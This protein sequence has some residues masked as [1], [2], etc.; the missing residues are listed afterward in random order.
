MDWSFYNPV[1]IFM[2]DLPAFQ[3]RLAGVF[4]VKRLGLLISRRSVRDYGLDSAIAA[5]AA[6]NTVTSID[7]IPGNPTFESIY[8]GLSL[9]GAAQPEALIAIGGGSTI[10]TAKAIS[11]V[12]ADWPQS[13]PQ[14]YQVVKSKSYQKAVGGIP[15]VAVPTTAGSGAD[16]TMWGTVWDA[17]G[18]QKYSVEAPWLYP[19]QSWIVPQ[20]TAT[21]PIRLTL[22]TG[23]DAL[24][25]ATE[26]Y[27]STRS[28]V[29]VREHARAAI[30]LI[31]GALAQAMER[32]QDME[33]RSRMCRGAL[34]AGLA[35]SNTRTTACHGLSYPLTL[36]FGIAH[37]FAVA[38]T[39]Y[40]VLALN[41]P[42][43]EEKGEFLAAWGVREPREIKAWLDTVSAP[44]QKLRLSAFGVSVD[45]A[46]S[47]L[48]GSSLVRE[49]MGNN[50]V[51]LSADAIARI[52]GNIQ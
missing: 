47:V 17:V 51:E 31:T 44:T 23:L 42:A 52:I 41:W 35:F 1:K 50:P 27:W 22:A 37:G 38:L 36:H 45:D 30:R 15:I 32:P 3:T 29:I 43:V 24:S 33:A 48:L 13:L 4:K 10:D 14:F 2:Y 12:S 18:K 9:F 5:L 19:A 8:D 39:L 34:F 49:R 11:A 6:Q 7:N 28:N 26:A 20:L 46:K 21:L 25:H 16:L 40:E